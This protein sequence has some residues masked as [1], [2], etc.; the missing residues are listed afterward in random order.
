MTIEAAGSEAVVSSYVRSALVI[1]HQLPP[2]VQVQHWHNKAGEITFS[3]CVHLC[4]AR[5]VKESTVSAAK[6][7][8]DNMSQG[9]V[10]R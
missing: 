9:L 10:Y 6:D 3:F 2:R 7:G 8:I 5:S 1:L 4:V